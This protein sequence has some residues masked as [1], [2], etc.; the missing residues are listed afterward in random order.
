LRENTEKNKNAVA[1][2]SFDGLH[3]G[4]MAVI[5]EAVKQKKRGLAPVAALFSDFPEKLLK[6]AEPLCLMTAEARERLLADKGVTSVYLNFAEIRNMEPERFFTNILIKELNAGFISCGFNYRF[7]KN[8]AGDKDTLNA[9]CKKYKIGFSAV[10]KVEYKGAAVSS[11]RI[12]E[13]LGQGGI[14]DA[15]AMLG[16]PFSYDGE[17]ARGAG[18]GRLLGAPTIN[19]YFPENLIK[20]KNGVYASET[21]IGKIWL[22][23]VTNIGVRPTVSGGKST[24]APRGETYIPDF[25]GDLYGK[26]IGVRLIKFIRPEKKFDSIER[27]K[28]A[29]KKDAET[30]KNWENK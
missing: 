26:N 4:H 30:V 19:Q 13:A 20:L 21:K 17:V 23:S 6:G 24:L 18:L 14:E 28:K 10:E 9:L 16:R 15:N 25:N 1:L 22:P 12:R 27:L 29:I 11:T 8:A 5:N 3:I 2:G 7:G